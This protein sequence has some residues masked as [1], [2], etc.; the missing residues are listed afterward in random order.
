MILNDLQ[1]LIYLSNEISKNCNAPVTIQKLHLIN[2][3]TYLQY[4]HWTTHPG[5]TDTSYGFFHSNYDFRSTKNWIHNKTYS[6]INDKSLN[7][8]LDLDFERQGIYYYE[9][10]E[11]GIN[12]EWKNHP[13]YWDGTT[14]IM[15]E[16]IFKPFE[17]FK[18]DDQVIAFCTAKYKM[19]DNKYKTLLNELSNKTA[20]TWSNLI[21]QKKKKKAK[22]KIRE[23]Q[24]DFE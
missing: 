14:C 11:L 9:N 18:N 1:E 21:I 8:L 20:K 13:D 24:E 16:Y 5:C 23:L 15:G 6:T 10:L 22:T 12:N 4:I 3:K 7:T 19:L 2:E 17:V